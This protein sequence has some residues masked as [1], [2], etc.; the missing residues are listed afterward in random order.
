MTTDATIGWATPVD[1]SCGT[2]QNPPILWLLPVEKRGWLSESGFQKLKC[3]KLRRTLGKHSSYLGYAGSL[4]RQPNPEK[5]QTS[6]LFQLVGKA[7]YRAM[8]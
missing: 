2:S 4:L 5:Y 3:P 8:F 1:V 6:N 7:L